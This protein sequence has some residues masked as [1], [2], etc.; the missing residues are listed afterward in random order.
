MWFVLILS[1]F[2]S[3]KCYNIW[4]EARLKLKGNK[5]NSND[6]S[7]LAIFI[8]DRYWK[9]TW[10]RLWISALAIYYIT[11]VYLISKC[12]WWLDLPFIMAA[13]L[14]TETV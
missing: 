14:E 1:V 5:Y 11:V 9:K 6:I 3:F 2:L 12:V 13:A 4:A 7:D 10:D 8:A